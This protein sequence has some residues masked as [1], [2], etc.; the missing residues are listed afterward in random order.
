MTTI[1]SSVYNNVITANV[2]DL[3]ITVTIGASIA[4]LS[5]V[6]SDI[7]LPFNGSGGN[8]GL[9][10]NS[11]DRRLELYVNGNMKAYWDES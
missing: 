11:T 3:T 10:Y 9:K 7:L 4:T 6:S 2:N 1:N 5:A 8:T